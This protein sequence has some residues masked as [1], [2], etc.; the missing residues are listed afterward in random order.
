M[1]ITLLIRNNGKALN[2]SHIDSIKSAAGIPEDQQVEVIIFGVNEPD[3]IRNSY[4][5][6][7]RGAH[8]ACMRLIDANMRQSSVDEAMP[9]DRAWLDD[10]EMYK[11]EDQDFLRIKEFLNVRYQRYLELISLESELQP[12]HLHF[13]NFLKEL[14]SEIARIRKIS[15]EKALK[16]LGYADDYVAMTGDKPILVTVTDIPGGGDGLYVQMDIPQQ[17]LSDSQIDEILRAK[18]KSQNMPLWYV[19]MR[20]EEKK[21]FDYAMMNVKSRNDVQSVISSIASKHRTI[22]GV[23]NFLKHQTLIMTNDGVVIAKPPVRYRSSM[24]SSRELLK[25]KNTKQILELRKQIAYRNAQQIIQ[26]AIDEILQDPIKREKYIDPVTNR[27]SLEA[28]AELPILMQT[29]ISPIGTVT[30]AQLAKR[31]DK[32]LYEDKIAVIKKMQKEGVDIRLP[33]NGEIVKIKFSNIL[34]TN[35]P[36]NPARHIIGSDGKADSLKII[37]LANEFIERTVADNKNKN[38]LKLIDPINAAKEELKDLIQT[39]PSTFMDNQLQLHKAALEEFIV[40]R[41]GG[42]SYGSCV[43]G[44]D[45]KG[46]ETIYVDALEIYFAKH[47]RLPT[48]SAPNQRIEFAKIYADLF[49][50]RHQHKS[51]GLNALGSDG[52]KS[53]KTYLPAYIIKE[54]IALDKNILKESSLLANNNEFYK[55]KKLF[56]SQVKQSSRGSS[57]DFRNVGQQ[58]GNNEIDRAIGL[59]IDLVN[60]DHWKSKTGKLVIPDGIS[61][62]R[63]VL[64]QLEIK[65]SQEFLNLNDAEREYLRGQICLGFGTITQEIIGKTS[66]MRESMTQAFYEI[67]D[68]LVKDR[69]TIL[70]GNKYQDLLMLH[71]SVLIKPVEVLRSL[72]DYLQSDLWKNNCPEGV[73]RI[74]VYLVQCVKNNT[75]QTSPIKVL[76]KIADISNAFTRVG[77]DLFSPQ[78]L[79]DVNNNL[80]HRLHRCI[81]ASAAKPYDP[82]VM[83]NLMEEVRMQ[84]P[85]A[86]VPP[87]PPGG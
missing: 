22:P 38:A 45:R 33:P 3:H 58:H 85:A 8:D 57:L 73:G 15:E 14:A 74:K 11:S 87:A 78:A 65:S 39:N 16:W 60:H 50:S 10:I 40:S 18:P 35:H 17:P 19:A 1:S 20:D 37:G 69:T 30:L 23:A 42:V 49:V 82:N 55:V 75:V 56:E 29:L 53:V 24:I 32:A 6:R 86:H 81:T 71:D 67:V 9:L 41:I 26:N 12:I 27:V 46:L 52:I 70:P 80:A 72:N 63:N 13:Q 25:L 4:L 5:Q 36:L 7:M 62:F 48:L 77:G 61:Q 54:I 51:A 59:M 47:D 64:K 44:K 68:N 31:P 66:L 28:L 21:L 84:A 83:Q 43:S 79:E 34:S 76:Q 2:S